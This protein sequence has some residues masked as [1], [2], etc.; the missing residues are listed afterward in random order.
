MN[1]VEQLYDSDPPREWAREARHRTEFAVTRRA[2]ADYLPPVPAAVADLGGGPGRY[3]IPLA[4]QGYAVTLVD[5]SQANLALA[6]A[7]VAE[8][9]VELAAVIHANVLSLPTLPEAQYDAILL[10]GPL[11]HLLELAE[12]ETAVAIAHNLLKPGGL[13]F[14]AFITRFAPFRD[15][16][17]KGYVDWIATYAERARLIWETGQNPAQPGNSFSDSVDPNFIIEVRQRPQ[18]N[19]H[20]HNDVPW[21]E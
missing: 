5:L 12:R 15:M 21:R 4:Q 1:P 16:A 13:I 19:G 11:Y 17:S 3:A 20:N 6:Q 7:K 18:S 2:L 9:G 8:V 10:L 14:A